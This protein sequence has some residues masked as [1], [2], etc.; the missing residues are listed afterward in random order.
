MSGG[1]PVGPDPAVEVVGVSVGARARRRPGAPAA[2]P[3]P[4][5]GT[6]R[7]SVLGRLLGALVVSGVVVVLL[8][9]YVFPT[10][11]YLDQRAR[12]AEGRTRLVELEAD[13]ARL[14]ARIAALG[15][16]AEIE[17]IARQTYGLV[18]PGEEAYRILPAPL[19]PGL[20]PVWPVRI[21]TA[22]LSAEGP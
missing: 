8:G 12:L 11:T 21:V 5:R 9:L 18:A 6:G 13:N 16:D 2:A 4:G 3:R 15:D 10:R 14:R 22:Q 17:R 7:R 1:G 20:P 19:D